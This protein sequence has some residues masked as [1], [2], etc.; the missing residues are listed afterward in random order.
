MPHY[1]DKI[2]EFEDRL[3]AVGERLE[4]LYGAKFKPFTFIQVMVRKRM[5]PVAIAEVLEY[6]AEN[7]QEIKVPWAWAYSATIVRSRNQYEREYQ[8]RSRFQKREFGALIDALKKM[9]SE[10]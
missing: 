2:P 4:R 7:Y 6:M 3:K 9:R 5:H 8:D 1:A 10:L